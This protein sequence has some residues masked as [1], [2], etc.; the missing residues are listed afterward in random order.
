MR[1]V[2]DQKPVK[3]VFRIVDVSDDV[4]DSERHPFSLLGPDGASIRLGATPRELADYALNVLDAD[5]V[6]HDYDLVKAAGR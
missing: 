6:R 4:L 3:R 5:A 1:V 2:T